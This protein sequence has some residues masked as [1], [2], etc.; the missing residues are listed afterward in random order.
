M[1]NEGDIRLSIKQARRLHVLE[2]VT[3]R[4]ITNREASAALGLSVRQVQR[5]KAGYEEAG[6]SSLVHGNTGRKPSNFIPTHVRAL[7]ADRASG[8]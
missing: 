3:G 4:A 6:A 2:E 5:I 7:V 8:L 1:K